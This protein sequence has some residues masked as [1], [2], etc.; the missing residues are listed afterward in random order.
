[1]IDKA[2]LRTRMRMVRDMVDDHLMRSVQL[3]AKVA[4][5][6]EY[7]QATSV[8]AFV[9]FGGEPDTDPLFAR[10]TAEGKR[11]LLPRV[12]ATGI[13]PADGDG[14]LVASK[15]GVM[16]PTG[17]PVDV[18]EIDFVIVPGLAFTLPGDRLGYGQGYYDRFLPTV[19]APNAGVCFSDQLVD[20]MPLT[21]HDIRVDTVISA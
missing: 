18:G 3:W 4:E 2:T 10:L 15:F 12:E 6:P 21:D 17:P 19:S 11:L 1:M 13:V 8:M 14:L 9:G 20:E 7:R 16:E 5:L